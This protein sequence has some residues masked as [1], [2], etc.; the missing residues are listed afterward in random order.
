MTGTKV[1][2]PRS[3]TR[4]PRYPLGTGAFSLF[5][6]KHGARD[7]VSVDLSDKYMKWLEQNLSLNPE[8]KL[9]HHQSITKPVH[10]AIKGL[11]KEERTFDFLICDPP[12]ASTDG[13]KTSSSFQNYV[14]FLPGFVKLVNQGGFLLLFL[15]THQTGLQKFR[16]HIKKIL[17]KNQ[18]SDQVREQRTFGLG[19][20]CPTLRGFQEG[21]YIKGILLQVKK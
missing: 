2:H 13:K 10:K 5:A 14:E 4:K 12:S 21:N 20:D 11:Q 16:N 7:V 19:E 3:Q 9:G 17:E 18:L 6:L 8:F 15:N 1:D